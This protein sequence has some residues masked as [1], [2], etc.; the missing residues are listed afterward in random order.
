MTRIKNL[1]KIILF[2]SLAVI[3]FIGVV[4]FG[5]LPGPGGL[6]LFLAGLGLLAVNHEWAKRA[7]DKVKNKT[8]HFRQVL[9][10]NNPWV[11]YGYDFVASALFF[12]SMYLLLTTNNPFLISASLATVCFSL[13]I[14][15][16]NRKRIDKLS[17]KF[18]TIK[19]KA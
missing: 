11:Q 19:R 4:L 8:T 13:V 16:F 5:W 18:K 6:P 9:F 3:C 1:T 14:L 17:A 12:V 15:L 2:D 7:L 10:P